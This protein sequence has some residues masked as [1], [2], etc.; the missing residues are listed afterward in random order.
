V[1]DAEERNAI[2]AKA[3]KIA[4]TGK[5]KNQLEPTNKE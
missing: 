3:L 2:G 1:K 4:G 5:V